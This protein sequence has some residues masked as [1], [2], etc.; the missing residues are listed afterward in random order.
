MEDPGLEAELAAVLELCIA[1]VTDVPPEDEIEVDPEFP[2]V[3]EIVWLVAERD[4]DCLVL[5]PPILTVV[6]IGDGG[7]EALN[8]CDTDDAVVFPKVD[9]LALALPWQLTGTAT[10]VARTAVIEVD[11]SM[12]RERP[13][14]AG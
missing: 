14:N 12:F 5:P 3:R 11:V 8:A 1:E 10:G 4:D 7:F 13:G 2:F 9:L 6:E